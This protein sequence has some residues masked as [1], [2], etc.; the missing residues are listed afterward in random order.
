[1]P[2]CMRYCTYPCCIC[3]GDNVL[4][5]EEVLHQLETAYI[6]VRLLCLKIS[7]DFVGRK[8]FLC[9]PIIMG[10]GHSA[11]LWTRDLG[12][13]RNP[14]VIRAIHFLRKLVSYCGMSINPFLIVYT[15]I[16]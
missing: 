12:S 11:Q 9:V 4:S 1:M 6:Y 8:D 5:F 7:S 15:C 2:Q 10:F 16:L 14:C 13:K 3:F